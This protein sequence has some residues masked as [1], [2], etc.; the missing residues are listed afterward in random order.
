MSELAK[1]IAGLHLLRLLSENRNNQNFAEFVLELLDLSNYHNRYNLE[2][3]AEQI[4][5]LLTK[6]NLNDDDEDRTRD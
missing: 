4:D 2:I 6:Y 3:E 5:H 1:I